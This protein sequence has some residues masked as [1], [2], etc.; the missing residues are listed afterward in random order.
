MLNYIEAFIKD[1]ILIMY[2][3]K[4]VINKCVIENAQ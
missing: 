1:I 3:I 4:T 2:L